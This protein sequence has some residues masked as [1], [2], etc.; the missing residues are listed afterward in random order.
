MQAAVTADYF[1]IIIVNLKSC[2]KMQKTFYNSLSLLSL[3]SLLLHLSILA[4]FSSFMA[5]LL[6]ILS[7]IQLYIFQS[8]NNLP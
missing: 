7:T 5:E 4:A 2:Y 1:L 6:L 3:L 8:Q